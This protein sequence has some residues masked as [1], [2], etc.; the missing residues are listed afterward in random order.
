MDVERAN[1]G[2]MTATGTNER[3]WANGQGNPCLRWMRID[4]AR[5]YAGGVSRKTLYA[6]VTTG[7]LKAARIG[8][9]RNLLFSLAF[10][11]EWLMHSAGPLG[12]AT[13]MET[14]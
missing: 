7:K 9:G 6:A 10:I 3:T 2:L 4:E 11:D 8:A 1:G 13:H 14:Q 5:A 12:H